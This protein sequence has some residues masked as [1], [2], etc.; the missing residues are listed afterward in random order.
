MARKLSKAEKAR[1]GR[2]VN[3]S[4][5]RAL[6]QEERALEFY[7]NQGYDCSPIR[8]GGDLA[9]TH[10]TRNDI[11]VEAKGRGD[12]SRFLPHQEEMRK[13]MGRNYKIFYD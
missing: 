11:V 8:Y 5:R 10:P 9:C 3:E 13:K 7:T 6:A 1:R 2:V 4:R 12:R